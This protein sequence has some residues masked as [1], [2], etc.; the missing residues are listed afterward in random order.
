MQKTV[1][2]IAEIVNGH[3]LGDADAVVTGFSTARQAA[4]GDLTFAAEPRYLQ[5][6]EESKAEAAIVRRDMTSASKTLVQVDSPYEAFLAVVQALREP[7]PA[8]PE[9]VHP[10][11]V[12][13]EGCRLG[14]G[15]SVG[16]NVVLGDHCSLGEGV[17][18]HAN[19]VIGR[20]CTVGADTVVYPNAT[21]REECIIGARCIIHAGAVIGSDGFGFFLKDGAR[22]KIPQTGIVELGDDVEVG[23]NSTI[24]RATFGKTIIGKG[25]KIDNLVQIGHNTEIGEHCVLCG[26]AGVSG[27][28]KI[29][30]Y[31]TLAAGS[32][33]SGHLEIGDNV[34]VA[35]LAGVTKSIPA[36]QVVSGFPA[37]DHA[38][39]RRIKAS[40]RRLPDALKEL[41]GLKQRIEEL[42]SLLHGR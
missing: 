11:A 42:E 36:N 37:V 5:I 31:C 35:A 21:I 38:A 10:S 20:G 2:E 16:P 8:P 25:T 40:Q 12:V 24:D 33:V 3:V 13:G 15:V 39:E 4:Q 41:R 9:G 1:S 29:G 6:V 27:S 7:S 22:Q 23:A 17:I 28:A 30:N 32:G 18:V 19:S 14:Q 26:N 34:T